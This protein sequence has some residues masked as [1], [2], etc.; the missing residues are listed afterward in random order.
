MH[1]LMAKRE[2]MSAATFDASLYTNNMHSSSD[3]LDH[4]LE[5]RA[6]VGHVA[7]T[8]WSRWNLVSHGSTMLVLGRRTLIRCHVSARTPVNVLG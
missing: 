1:K 2:A 7:H 8:K 5:D 4:L 6:R 3:V